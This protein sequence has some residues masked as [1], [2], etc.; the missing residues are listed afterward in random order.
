PFIPL[1]FNT[2]TCRVETY[3]LRDPVVLED[4]FLTHPRWALSP[5]LTHTNRAFAHALA[6]SITFGLTS[7]VNSSRTVGKTWII[8]AAVNLVPSFCQCVGTVAAAGDIGNVGIANNTTRA[9]DGSLVPLFRHALSVSLD[10]DST[11]PDDLLTNCV[12][13]EISVSRC[14]ILADQEK[15]IRLDRLTLGIHENTERLLEVDQDDGLCSQNSMFPVEGVAIVAET[16][17]DL[18]GDGTAIGESDLTEAQVA[19]RQAK[20]EEAARLI[21]C[22]AFAFNADQ[23]IDLHLIETLFAEVPLAPKSP[24]AMRRALVDCL[25]NLS[26]RL[27]LSPLRIIDSF[28]RLGLLATKR[29]PKLYYA[30]PVTLMLA[31]MR[32]VH[33]VYNVE[34]TGEIM[35]CMAPV[36]ELESS[37]ADISILAAYMVSPSDKRN[38][39]D[40]L[41]ALQSGPGSPPPSTFYFVSD[42]FAPLL[43]SYYPMQDIIAQLEVS[44]P[45]T[46]PTVLRT[47]VQTECWMAVNNTV[48]NTIE[49]T[50][51][52]G[53]LRSLRVPCM[54]LS[55]LSKDAADVFA[56]SQLLFKTLAYSENLS[57]VASSGYTKKSSKTR[58]KA[59]K[60]HALQ[61]ST[62]GESAR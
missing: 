41:T 10:F 4:F 50:G 29:E 48:A 36:M 35:A 3:T 15:S 17:F 59:M 1:Q 39:Q 37:T 25:I 44:H 14:A 24:P 12:P 13:F 5:V 22:Y 42:C 58:R 62:D 21:G 38:W 57:M 19:Q 20:T 61:V 6:A 11:A 45:D 40:I 8:D 60:M 51:M 54:S 34:E 26:D 23:L 52:S 30:T 49:D 9:S 53:G 55:L 56:A 47:A 43:H 7:I 32:S 28:R 2:D 33:R 46:V 16:H 27:D 18:R 31:A